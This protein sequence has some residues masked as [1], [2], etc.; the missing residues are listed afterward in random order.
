VSQ[1]WE[2]IYA[3]H[4]RRLVTLM[5][6]LCGST[7]DAE[8][9][10]QEAF[11]RGLGM[12]GRR[13]PPDDPQA[14]LYRVASNV[15]K[16]RWRRM[17]VAQRF[18]PRLA[19]GET[20]GS[21]ADGSDDRLALVTAMRRLPM[22][23]REAPALHYFADMSVAAIADRIEVPV[24]TV[25]ARLSRGRDSLAGLLA[26]DSWPPAGMDGM[27]GM[28]RPVDMDRPVNVDVRQP[29]FTVIE[30][31]RARRGRRAAA[32]AALLTAIVLAGVAW[33]GSRLPHPPPI[34]PTPEPSV[35][36]QP[37]P[38]TSPSVAPLPQVG[39]GP[40]NE[41]IAVSPAGTVF[42]LRR[43]CIARCGQDNLQERLVLFRSADRGRTWMRA[44]EVPALLGFDGRLAVSDDKVMWIVAV[45]TLWGTRDGGKSWQDW[46][47][48]QAGAFDTAGGRLWLGTE[49]GL[50]VAT[51]GGAPARVTRGLPGKAFSITQVVARTGDAAMA[52]IQVE[53]EP[54]RWYRSDDKGASWR[55]MTQPCAGVELPG[56]GQQPDEFRSAIGATPDGDVLWAICAEEPTSTQRKAL[57]ISLDAGG[58]WQSRGTL[59]SPGHSFLVQPVN[60]RIAWREGFN[61]DT[62]I[63]RT[64]DART[65]TTVTPQTTANILDFVV[66]GGDTAIVIDHLNVYLT[67]D[68]GRTWTTNPLPA[69]SPTPS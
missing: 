1:A 40:S 2:E 60:A 6:A 27:D 43:E 31:R 35:S 41:S 64:E 57:A 68:A 66:I 10:V 25:K 65:W 54:D 51:G 50:M 48:P 37:N 22:E 33:G 4:Y 63:M 13:P 14:W 20:D 23:Q 62:V 34:T 12:T 24:G 18:W 21:P 8:E 59:E 3:S 44:G 67:K 55:V 28:D 7:S 9:A 45:E 47:I 17:K 5:T 15:V 39:A 36:P 11:A 49:T 30:K 26:A 56:P 58:A 42:V 16:A 29:S 61:V 38:S 69:Q 32:G 46:T 52:L 19:V 53:S